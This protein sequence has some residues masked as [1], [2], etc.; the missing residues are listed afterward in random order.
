MSLVVDP[1]SAARLSLSTGSLAFEAAQGSSAAGD[2]RIL[3]VSNTGGGDLIWRAEMVLSRGSDWLNISQ[4]SGTARPDRP[5]DIAVSVNPAGLGTG[6][7][8][9]LI[10]VTHTSSGATATVLVSLQVSPPEGR[11]LLST[12]SMTFTAV[13]GSNFIPSQSLRVLNQGQGRMQWQ[14]RARTEQGS[15]LK[16]S[17]PSGES[18]RARPTSSP[19]A[20]VEVDP[21]ELAPGLYGGLLLVGAPDARNSPQV[22]SVLLR[23]L[24]AGSAPIAT[25]SPTGVILSGTVGS[26]PQ[27]QSVALQTTGGAPLTY[28][29]G[30]AT[31][32]G[33]GWLTV[34]PAQGS[35]LSSAELSR[36]QIQATPGTLAA[37][38]YRGSVNLTFGDGR[39]SEVAVVMVLRAAASASAARQQ[40]AELRSTDSGDERAAGE[41]V[42]TRQVIVSTRLGNSFSIPTGWPAVL[43]T[44][45]TD[46]CG[47]AVPNSTV[48]V[49]FSTGDTPMLLTNLRDGFYT[50][51]WV[52]QP[53]AAG[54]SNAVQI[55]LRALNPGLQESNLQ[56]TGQIA[57][58]T[59]VING[60]PV[61]VENGTVN[62]SSFA[63]LQPISPGSIVTI[64]G[65]DLASAGA[66]FGG[67][68]ATSLPLP[69]VLGGASVKIGGVDAPIFFAGPTQINAQVPVELTGQN[70]ADVVV[71]ARGIVSAA[72]AIQIDPTQPGIFTAGGTQGAILNE[73]FS[74]NSISNPID[75]GSVLQIFATG[76]GP[77]EPAVQTG[78][79]AP[80]TPPFA[81]LVNPVAISIGGAAASVEFQALA[82][83]FVGLYQINVR[84]PA[85][86][87]PGNTV[88]LR[89][90]QSGITSNQVT[91]AI[92]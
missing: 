86:I 8:L 41:C 42:P 92:R 91:V 62:A 45:V 76:L 3:S 21:G 57:Q 90:T 38:I 12:D 69:T 79:P 87:A 60:L 32:D 20:A 67:N 82:P 31:S 39:T 72:Q 9:G 61:I 50:G 53:P 78:Q 15:W 80:L 25:V 11:I 34:S 10:T 19:E 35:L 52:P 75:R 63:P 83:G 2:S 46:D 54:P 40:V 81:T 13:Q 88:P 66:C 48:S 17:T 30:A 7:Y 49:S 27:R 55:T 4:S 89:I 29:A 64:F 24:P 33:A 59:A 1:P 84:V 51:T 58:D 37:G 36:L 26:G 85:N 70:S 5:N 22:V 28:S 18:D 68:C 74:P 71:S 47:A 43:A 73:N 6:F 56:L 65:R 14:L 23:V 44:A 77:T 16:V